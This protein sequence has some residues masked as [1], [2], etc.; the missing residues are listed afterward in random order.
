M[1]SPDIPLYYGD[2]RKGELP[3]KKMDY[4]G[5]SMAAGEQAGD[6]WA[7]MGGRIDTSKWR[8][9][10]AAFV[11]K[12]PIPTKNMHEKEQTKYELATLHLTPEEL[13][14]MVEFR[15]KMVPAHVAFAGKALA[16][17]QA[18]EDPTGLLVEDVRRTLPNAVRKLIV[19]ETYDTWQ[20][21]H[22]GMTRIPA[23]EEAT[24]EAE[25]GERLE[26]IEQALSLGTHTP[27][28][29]RTQQFYGGGWQNSPSMPTILRTPAPISP[30]TPTTPQTPHTSPPSRPGW[31]TQS[32]PIHSPNNLFFPQTAPNTLGTPSPAGTRTI[33]SGQ[34]AFENQNLWLPFAKTPA[35]VAAYQR[36]IS[37][38]RRRF[39]M[40]KPSIQNPYPLRP[41]GANLASGE[42]F[43]CGKKEPG[44]EHMAR[45]CRAT[46]EERIPDEER[47]WRVAYTS[48]MTRHHFWCTAC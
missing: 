29:Q 24:R 20:E 18:I 44:R 12:W 28:A 1:K 4:F 38:W 42:C 46:E 21:F 10:K 27:T 22:D 40:A 34:T 31:Q 14:T 11:A 15:G 35:G 41:G 6:W 17:A 37:E 5:L 30:R 23:L 26:R 8:I 32:R 16:L 13:G 36:A 43:I 9:V 47:Y 48:H 3:H 45:D 39:G 25:T 33:Q 2:Y 7:E 19:N